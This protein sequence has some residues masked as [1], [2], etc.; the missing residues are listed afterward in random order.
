MFKAA[1][2]SYSKAGKDWFITKHYG[3]HSIRNN[4]HTYDAID[5]FHRYN[6]I[7][8]YSTITRASPLRVIIYAKNYCLRIESSQ[9]SSPYGAHRY[10]VYKLSRGMVSIILHRKII[11]S[12]K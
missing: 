5:I 4:Q 2:K 11:I 8:T 6:Y 7:H 1:K 12:I 9:E 3:I 10:Q